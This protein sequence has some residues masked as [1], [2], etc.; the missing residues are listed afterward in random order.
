MSGLPAACPDI[1][2]SDASFPWAWAVLAYLACLALTAWMHRKD[3]RE[4]PEKGERYRRLP[5]GY[6]LLC[7]VIVIPVL[8][9]AIFWHPAM[10]LLGLVAFACVEGACVRWYRRHGLY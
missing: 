9:S 7:P 4:S 3:F 8:V 2:L 5:I 10:Y 1:P 6:K